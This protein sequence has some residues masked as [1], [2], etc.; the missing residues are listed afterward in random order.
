MKDAGS[1]GRIPRGDARRVHR[2]LLAHHGAPA[3]PEPSPSI[4][5]ALVETILSQNTSDANSS[6]AFASLK[7]RFPSWDA[8]RRA[9]VSSLA[10]AI[11]AGGLAQVKAPRI[12]A[13]LRRVHELYGETSLEHLAEQEDDELRAVLGSFRGVGPKTVACVLL[14]HLGRPD[15][16]V[17]THVHRV[18]RRL[19]WIAARASAEEAYRALLPQ[20][21]A[22]IR[23]ELHVL[24]VWHGRALCRAR[25]AAC[26]ACPI[27]PLCATGRLTVSEASSRAG[28]A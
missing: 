14:F 26:G 28:S 21:P 6:R 12:R 20:V 18:A 1:S 7:A 3:A 17:D 22:A 2:V 23:Y 9:R 25:R 10:S 19:G 15:F 5:D 24:L 11:R 13:I 27:R 4:L 8:A 16:P